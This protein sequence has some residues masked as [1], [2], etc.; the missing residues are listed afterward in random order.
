MP[1]LPSTRRERQEADLERKVE[2]VQRDQR[3]QRLRTRRMRRLIVLINALLIVLIIPGYAAWGPIAGIIIT[4]AAWGG[5]WLLR[6][7]VRTVADLPDRFLDERQ[8]QLRDRAY[9]E[10]YKIFGFIVTGLATIGLVAFTALSENDEL[11]LTTQWPQAFGLVMFVIL[12]AMTLPSM[13]L[14]WRDAGELDA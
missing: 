3:F 4:I 2:R 7:S 13:T 6:T 1:H 9:L 11:T 5:W 10:A 12:L 8:R 14:A